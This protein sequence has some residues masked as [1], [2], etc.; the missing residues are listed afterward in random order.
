MD[1]L[2]KHWEKVLLTVVLLALIVAAAVLVMKVESLRDELAEAPRRPRKKSE[3]ATVVDR[4]PYTAAIEQLQKPFQWDGPPVAFIPADIKVETDIDTQIVKRVECEILLNRVIRV[5]FKM[6]FKAYVG[7]GRNFQVD[8]L[9]QGFTFFVENVG[10]PIRD[11]GYRVA[12]FE[13]KFITVL[14]ASL[15][16]E[17]ERDVSELT[18]ER[19]GEK[20]KI[21]TVGREA[22]EEEPIATVVCQP[23]AVSGGEPTTFRLRRGQSFACCN[24]TY[25]VV[26]ITS[27]QMIIKEPES[28]EKRAISLTVPT[29]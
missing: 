11:T 2:K 4:A 22:V 5:P 25:N 18:I 19:P 8:L 12:R 17:V 24:K 15:N 28:E 6:N 16:R 1:F 21:L 27:R 13:K 7:D 3:P 20:P 26:D 14:D 29:E 23:T 10:D 9:G